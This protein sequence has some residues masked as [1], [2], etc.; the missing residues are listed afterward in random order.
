MEETEEELRGQ[1]RQLEEQEEENE[2]EQRRVMDM[3]EDQEMVLR[4]MCLHMEEMQES[5]SQNYVVFGLMEEKRNLITSIQNRQ[6]ELLEE[7]Q[8][9]KRKNME[10]NEDKRT[11]I[12]KKLCQYSEHSEK[13]E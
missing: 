6:Y 4:R 2:R 1:L 12:H 5:Y 7:M 3:E 8:E 10:E 9:E 11:E 13:D